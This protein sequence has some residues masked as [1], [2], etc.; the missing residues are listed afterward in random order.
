V[1][2]VEHIVAVIL[3]QQDGRMFVSDAALEA[4]QSMGLRV[5]RDDAR[6]GYVVSLEPAQRDGSGAAGTM[7]P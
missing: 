3:G 4:V 2:P 1:I 5:E 6:G 7:E